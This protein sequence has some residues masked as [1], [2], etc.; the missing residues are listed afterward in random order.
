MQSKLPSDTRIVGSYWNLSWP[1][2]Q[3][4][5]EVTDSSSNVT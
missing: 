5:A 2:R 4:S 1:D 3:E